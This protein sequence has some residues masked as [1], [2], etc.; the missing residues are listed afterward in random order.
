MFVIVAVA[1]ALGNLKDNRAVEPLLAYL[2]HVN[3]DVRAEVASALGMIGDRKATIPLIGA[4]GDE[5]PWVRRNSAKALGEIKD[6]LAV[7]PLIISFTRDQVS[8]VRWWSVHALGDISDPRA[9]EPLASIVTLKDSQ[10]MEPL[11]DVLQL[12]GRKRTVEHPLAYL[13]KGMQWSIQIEAIHSLGRMGEVALPHLNSTLLEHQDFEFRK[14]AAKMIMEI[15]GVDYTIHLLK[16]DDQLR[17]TKGVYDYVI[18]RGESGTEDVLVDAL[19]A[20]GEIRMARDFIGSE[21]S[22]LAKAAEVWMDKNGYEQ[23]AK[24]P[25]SGPKWGNAR[26]H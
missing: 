2:V 20:Y 26:I 15:K 19:N 9:M 6:P 23:P 17:V 16:S 3:P 25:E 13:V 11:S 4:L 24:K 1:T 7:D 12:R 8:D 5:S 22:R 18:S 21:N 10:G 14:E